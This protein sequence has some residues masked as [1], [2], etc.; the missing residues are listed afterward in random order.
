MEFSQA[1]SRRSFLKVLASGATVTLT[2]HSLPALALASGT[3]AGTAAPGVANAPAWGPVPGKARYRIDG[4][5]KVLGQKIYARDFTARDFKNWPQNKENWLYALRCNRSDSAVLGYD[6]SMLPQ[7]LMPIAVIDA[8]ALAA[9][10]MQPKAANMNSPFFTQIGSAPDFYGQPVAML[11]FADF[12]A[13]RR[14]VKILQF[15]PD[16]IQYGAKQA[17][18]T[19][20]YTP[21]T[22][23]VRDDSQGFNYV[24][25]ATTYNAQQYRVDKEVRRAIDKSDWLKL[26][27]SFYTQTI[28]PMFMEPEAGM[29]W[30]DTATQNLNLVLGTQS[31]T[32]DLTDC[33]SIFVGSST[34]NC[35]STPYNSVFGV[36]QIDILSC[37]PGGGFGGRDQSYFPMYLAMA[38]PFASGP[39]RWAQNRFEQFQVGLKRCETEFTETLAVDKNGMIQGL[40]CNYLM[41]GGGEKNLSP[42]VVQLAGMSSMSCYNIPRAVA[43]G[44]SSQTRQLLGGSQRGFG[45]PQA[46]M[47]IETL[48]DEACDKLKMDPFALRRK[49]LLGKGK[50]LSITGAPMTQDLQLDQILDKLEAHP[51][52]RNRYAKQKEMAAKGMKYGVGFAMSNEAYGTSSDG[53][54]G[55]VQIE[56][57]GSITV[58]TPYIDMGNGAA[59]ALGLAP[60]RS[61]GRN[62]MTINMGEAA[63]FNSLGLTTTQPPAGQPVPANYVAKG[64]G[65][66]SACLGAFHQ[67]H[68]VE[69]AGITLLIQSVAPAASALWKQNVAWKQIT[70]KDGQLQAAGLPA[71]PWADVVKQIGVMNLPTY[72][73]VHATFV[74]NFVTSDFAFGTGTVNLPLDYIAMGTSA[75]NLKPVTRSNMTPI[76]SENWRYGRSTYAP[77]GALVATS[78]NPKT[79]Y[80]KVEEVVSVLGAG[81]LHC[82]ELVEGQSQGGI[83][84]AIGNMLLEDCP[85]GPDGPGNG[86][87][88]LNRYA[89]ARVAD[90]P[91]QELIILPPGEGETTG[92]GIAEAVFCP[93]GPA[94]LN[95]LAMATGGKRFTSTPIQPKHVLEAIK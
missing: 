15:N 26:S 48:I 93:I 9:K 6:L 38:A 52:W 30:Y 16:T 85:I 11:I 8:A 71:L 34:V 54:F 14:A 58:H 61:M 66:S 50:G 47:A 81:V 73:A 40:L 36:K 62:A 17:I 10:K 28:D 13:Y 84:M 68:V 29:A 59:T 77:C 80:I 86:T 70:L 43:A 94:L 19:S 24:K 23:Y 33:L 74:V 82:R 46:F 44:A 79:G 90:V 95:G 57:D 83:L 41:N 42:Y 7:E 63:L 72:S 1:V 87:W 5:R 39:L 92:R 18:A 20:A 49:N 75:A 76:P 25:S 51:L 4:M 78:V 22:H 91:K 67:Y 89:V 12:N 27:R 69:Q 88:N 64:S 65:S 32:G 37:Y 31:P 55:A 60:A 3:P 2:V 53:M 56:A 35:Q 21:G 45:G